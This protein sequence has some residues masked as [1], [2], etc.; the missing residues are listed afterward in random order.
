MIVQ[1]SIL[2]A[3]CQA[4]GWQHWPSW[5]GAF[6]PVDCFQFLSHLV[7]P[8]SFDDLQIRMSSP[9]HGAVNQIVSV[10]LKKKK[11][12]LLHVWFVRLQGGCNWSMK[13]WSYTFLW[14]RADPAVLQV[15][16]SNPRCVMGAEIWAWAFLSCTVC[17]PLST[18]VLGRKEERKQGWMNG[19]LGWLGG[20]Q[21]DSY[22]VVLGSSG[23]LFFFSPSVIYWPPSSTFQEAGRKS[24]IWRLT[25]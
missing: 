25:T 20:P 15:Y 12:G 17:E 23:D 2:S 22:L 24:S 1:I 19:E 4:G 3:E 21:C 9:F 10:C 11:K 6:L 5:N 14:A 16:S 13:S 8:I 7:S 18:A